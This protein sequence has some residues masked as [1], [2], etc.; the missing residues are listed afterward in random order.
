MKRLIFAS[1][2]C[3]S[4]VAIY[5]SHTPKKTTITTTNWHEFKRHNYGSFEKDVAKLLEEGQKPALAF[6]YSTTSPV[7]ISDFAGAQSWLLKDADIRE[8]AIYE[9][10]KKSPASHKKSSDVVLSSNTTYTY[11]RQFTLTTTW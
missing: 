3:A 8:I 9:V 10:D 7:F 1:L 4:A 6:R 5:C 2:L 11:Y